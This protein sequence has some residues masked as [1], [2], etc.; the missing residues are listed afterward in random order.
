MFHMRRI[1]AVG[2]AAL[3]TLGL[4]ACGESDIAPG[5]DEQSSPTG[6]GA[7]GATGAT[8]ETGTTGNAGGK[9]EVVAVDYDFRL[10]EPPAAGETELVLENQGDE[11]HELVLMQLEQGRTMD[12]VTTF[13]EE[14]GLEGPPPEWVTVAGGT[15]AR[16]GKS[17]KPL[18]A[19]LESGA[20]YVMACFVETKDGVPHAALGMLDELDVA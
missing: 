3:V 11:P 13:I 15:F 17:S 19:T 18:R 7:T 20:T 5:T 12:D 6:V 1:A 9:A 8:T 14:Q 16:P 2:A 4:A 10:A